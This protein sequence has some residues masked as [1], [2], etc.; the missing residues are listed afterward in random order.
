MSAAGARCNRASGY[1]VLRLVQRDDLITA[2][3]IAVSGKFAGDLFGPDGGGRRPP[4]EFAFL[5]VERA[6]FV[7]HMKEEA[8]QFRSF[9]E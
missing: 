4:K 2:I 5:I 8:G 6:G 7:S 3:A 1:L 9:P